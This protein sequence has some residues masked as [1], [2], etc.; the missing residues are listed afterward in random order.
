MTQD[1]IILAVLVAAS[2]GM[3]IYSLL[4]ARKQEEEHVLRRMAGRRATDEQPLA[5]SA[6]R[7]AAKQMLE[8]VA[9]IAM[10]PVM[11]KSAEEMSTLREKLANAGFRHESATRYFLASKTIIGILL[12][13]IGL[14]FAWGKGYEL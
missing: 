1:M 13:G 3:I 14:T 11:P 5:K 7:S 8:K 10:R 9:P 4:P 2:V 12:A 6:S